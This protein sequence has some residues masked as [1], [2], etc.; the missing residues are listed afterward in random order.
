MSMKFWQIIFLFTGTFL[1][2]A[3]ILLTE[4]V[5]QAKDGE[6]AAPDKPYQASIANDGVQRVEIIGGSYF[7]T[8]NRIIVKVNIPVELK[9]R[10]ESGMIP[11]NIVVSAPEAGIA[12]DT[13]MENEAKSIRFTPTRVG[14]Y[15]F[16]CNKKL[17]FFESHREKGM[18]G[19]LEVVE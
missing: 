10:K 7:F 18:K 6:R 1:L 13:A 16:Y 2:T 5:S 14:S 9:V 19:V 4:D 11:H 8:P 17:L 3:T 15:P 12:F